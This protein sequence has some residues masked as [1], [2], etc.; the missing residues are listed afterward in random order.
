MVNH[1]RAGTWQRTWASRD[2]S[3]T[4]GQKVSELMQVAGYIGLTLEN[5]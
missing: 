1:A 3:A 4:A 5:R 2:R